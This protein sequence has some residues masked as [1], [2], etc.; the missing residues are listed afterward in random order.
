MQKI[1]SKGNQDSFSW[2]QNTDNIQVQATLENFVA[3]LLIL[4]YTELLFCIRNAF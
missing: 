1:L 3:Q 2:R 4:N